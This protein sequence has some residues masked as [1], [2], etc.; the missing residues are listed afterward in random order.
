MII[1]QPALVA[2]LAAAT[3]VIMPPD[4]ILESGGPAIVSISSVISGISSIKIG[5]LLLLGSEE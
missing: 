5:F 2:I 4:A 1:L 3:L